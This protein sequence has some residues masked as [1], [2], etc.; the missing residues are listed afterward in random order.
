MRRLTVF[1]NVT[2]DGYFT[3]AHGDMDWAYAGGGDPEFAAFTAENAGRSGALVFGRITYEMMASYWPT[4]MA[5]KANPA[6]ADGMNAM[7]KIVFSRTLRNPAWRNT[8]VIGGDP[9][10]AVAQLKAEPG[11]DMVILGSGTIVAQLAAA[12]LIDEYQLV[13]CP[14]VLGAG[15][16]MF[17]GLPQA[18]ALRLARSRTF[19]NGKV[20]A[21]YEPA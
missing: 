15:R 10:A 6:V 12:G 5:A 4:P 16:T 18:M 2:L 8:R 14:V 21:V 3:D 1:N 20:L 7:P 11:P 13:L 9:A 17:D 19:G